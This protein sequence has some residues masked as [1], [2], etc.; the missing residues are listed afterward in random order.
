MLAKL[1]KYFKNLELTDC[2]VIDDI[3]D[4]IPGI[5][6]EDQEEF[7][8]ICSTYL[9]EGAGTAGDLRKAML[10]ICKLRK[11]ICTLHLDQCCYATPCVENFNKAAVARMLHS[12]LL[13]IV[14]VCGPPSTLKIKN[15]RVLADSNGSATELLK[16]A[17]SSC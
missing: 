7:E 14:Q 13:C 8:N 6:S 1:R 3:R 9:S 12:S 5:T 4:L 10:S 15:H 11:L 17:V 16:D 2:L